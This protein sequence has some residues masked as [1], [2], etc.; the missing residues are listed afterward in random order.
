MFKPI[1][2]TYVNLPGNFRITGRGV[3]LQLI[4]YGHRA[5]M[6][7]KAWKRKILTEYNLGVFHYI[8]EGHVY[9]M[10]G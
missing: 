10:L 3:V 8:F 2:E 9:A 6:N 7:N 5:K 1:R 4:R